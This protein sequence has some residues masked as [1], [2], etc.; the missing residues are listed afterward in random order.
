MS[1]ETSIYSL[2]GIELLAPLSPADRTSLA[3]QC[4]WRRYAPHELIMD[5]LDNDT[6]DVCCVV[7]GRVRVVNHS[8]GGR[9]ISF[10]DVPSG[11]FLGELSALD[12]E[13]RSAT[14]EALDETLC[15]FIPGAVFLEL[16]AHNPALARALLL[17]LVKIIRRSTDRIMDLSTLGANNRVH[18]ELLCLAK[19]NLKRDNTAEIT[20]IPVHNDIAARVSTTRETVA[21][22]LNDLARDGIVERRSNVLVVRNFKALERMVEDVRGDL[23]NL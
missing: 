9:E 13:P 23:R 11:G 3:R 19:L 14:V 8:L 15:A 12:G 21:R 1:S 6:R 20:P 22:V 7:E 10:D 4:K 18:A 5:R 17:K 16:V 2:D